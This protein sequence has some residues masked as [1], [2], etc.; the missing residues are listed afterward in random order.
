IGSHIVFGAERYRPETGE[1]LWLLAHELAHVI[2]HG[3]KCSMPPCGVANADDP[4]ERAANRAA[5]LVAS[6]SKVPRDFAFGATAAG[7]I[8]CHQ[9]PPCGG[10]AVAA[11]PVAEQNANL[12]LEFAY[13]GRPDGNPNDIVVYAS[14]NYAWQGASGGIYAYANEL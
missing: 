3:G 5:G 7:V 8:Q 10:Y 11:D 4:L 13:R 1:G 14:N 6:G 9:G 12:L 2:Q